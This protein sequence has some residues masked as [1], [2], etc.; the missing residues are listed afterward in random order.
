MILAVT[1]GCV[2]G[3]IA[4]YLGN[5]SVYYRAQQTVDCSLCAELES[6]YLCQIGHNMRACTQK[7]V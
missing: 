1:A 3:S 7:N 4:R 6:V 5:C 2:D